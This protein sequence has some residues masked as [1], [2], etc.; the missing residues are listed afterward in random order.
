M[1]KPFL[2]SIEQVDGYFLSGGVD[3]DCGY[4]DE[5]SEFDYTDHIV[6]ADSQYSEMFYTACN[7]DQILR[8][9]QNLKE[10]GATHVYFNGGE[11]S[12]GLVIEGVIAQKATEDQIKKYELSRQLIE[13]ENQKMKYLE[14]QKDEIRARIGEILSDPYK[15]TDSNK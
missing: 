15:F 1:E 13:V 10:L 12:E 8:N 3:K 11:D 14:E 4:D 5:S 2:I 6:F 7:I 9:I